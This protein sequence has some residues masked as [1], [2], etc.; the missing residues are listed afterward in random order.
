MYKS[1]CMEWNLFLTYIDYC[2]LIIAIIISTII[3]DNKKYAFLLE[4]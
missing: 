3:K 2:I 1:Q 4:S